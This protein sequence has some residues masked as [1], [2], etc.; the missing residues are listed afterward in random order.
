MSSFIAHPTSALPPSDATSCGCSGC[1][2]SEA[3]TAPVETPFGAIS[4]AASVRDLL[5]AHP[6][7]VSILHTFGIDTCCGAGAS[8][9]DAAAHAG[10]DLGSVLV[11][12]DAQFGSRQV[13]RTGS[14]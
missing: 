10:A 4:A 12:L 3:I 5:L 9:R 1:S 11:S 8:L 2:E 7:A 6:Q 13:A 14:A